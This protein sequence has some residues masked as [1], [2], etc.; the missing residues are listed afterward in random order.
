[1]RFWSSL[2]LTLLL[3]LPGLALAEP[4]PVRVADLRL[5]HPFKTGL[6]TGMTFGLYQ[7]E[8]EEIIKITPD[9]AQLPVGFES[10]VKSH[11]QLAYGIG[12]TFG[13]G[14]TCLFLLF[15]VVGTYCRLHASPAPLEEA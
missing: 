5:Q 14:F 2:C 7:S 13:V 3:F 11:G 1:M 9:D 10:Y 12:M 8:R 4:E 15:L 6:A